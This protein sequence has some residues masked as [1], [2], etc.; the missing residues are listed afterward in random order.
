MVDIHSEIAEIKRGKKK[1]QHRKK[2]KPHGK[3]ITACPLLWAA[4]KILK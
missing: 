1:E 3:N 2:K 4:I